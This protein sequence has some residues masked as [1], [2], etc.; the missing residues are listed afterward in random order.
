MRRRRWII[1]AAALLLAG[2]IGWYFGSPHYT[3]WQMKRAV[4]NDD[5]DALASYVDFPAVRD[6]LKGQ[7][8]AQMRAEASRRN[9][10]VGGLALAF[11]PAVIGTMVDNIVT[12]AG[13]RTLLA[14]RPRR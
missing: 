1:A 7:L 10:A 9:D 4:E 11:G 13:V 3:M 5:A 2:A 12:P 6:D 8:T 14:N